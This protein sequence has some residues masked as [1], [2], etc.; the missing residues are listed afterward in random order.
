MSSVQSTYQGL[1]RWDMDVLKRYLTNNGIY[2]A[3]E[4]D[5][6]EAEYKK[7]LA[8]AFSEVA[9]GRS[10]PVS[11]KID[12]F[13]HTHILFT[14]DYTAMCR[15]FAGGYLHHRP[16]IL[17]DEKALMRSFA[18]RTLALYREHFGTP[19]PTFWNRAVCKCAGNEIGV[20]A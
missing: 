15:E 11:A 17:D 4:I 9:D 20:F 19:K 2:T 18:D 3:D 6:A 16:S 7:W 10:I 1:E 14:Q 8:L 5:E 13:W 12:D